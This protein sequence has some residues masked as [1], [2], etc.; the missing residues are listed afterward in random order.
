MKIFKSNNEGFNAKR[1]MSVEINFKGINNPLEA[2]GGS[3]KMTTSLVTNVEIRNGLI[4]FETASGS[5][6][7]FEI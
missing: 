3:F 6:Y 1:G 5:W 4:T 7:S 2:Y